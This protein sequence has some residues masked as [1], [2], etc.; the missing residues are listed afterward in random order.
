V[1]ADA[2]LTA[3]LARYFV[4]LILASWQTQAQDGTVAARDSAIDQ[5][6]ASARIRTV[7]RPCKFRRNSRAPASTSKP[8]MTATSRYESIG[9]GSIKLR[10]PRKV[11]GRGRAS[12]LRDLRSA[13]RERKISR[14][15]VTT[16]SSRVS[17]S[18]RKGYIVH[19]TARFTRNGPAYHNRGN[20]TSRIGT[21]FLDGE[22]RGVCAL[23][24]LRRSRS[25]VEEG[26]GR[27]VTRI[28]QHSLVRPG[29][30]ASRS[31]R[32]GQSLGR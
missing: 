15:S 26:L 12:I 30:S 9:D 29:G 5:S 20:V 14:Q 4:V 17:V 22:P 27:S 1:E 21:L 28:D 11:S 31:L 7:V 10:R 19:S 24:K 23:H 8:A 2:G 13:S 6:G 32:P 16:I 3:S 25:A 18:C